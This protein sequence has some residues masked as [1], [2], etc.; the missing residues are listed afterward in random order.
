MLVNRIWRVCEW[1]LSLWESAGE[2]DLGGVGERD[3]SSLE[4]NGEP[5]LGDCVLPLLEGGGSALCDLGLSCVGFALGDLVLTF[6]AGDE[7]GL[8]DRS[9]IFLSGDGSGGWSSLSFTSGS[10]VGGG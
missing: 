3:L 2:Q 6:L 7:T 8:D 5:E 1:D 4:S 9:F 10:G